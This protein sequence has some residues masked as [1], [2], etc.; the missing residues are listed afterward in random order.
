M[1]VYFVN[2]KSLHLIENYTRN[3]NLIY[4]LW[5]LNIPVEQTDLIWVLST[6]QIIII[7]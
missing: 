4:I 5:S 1:F 3:T 6:S 2:K 7:W